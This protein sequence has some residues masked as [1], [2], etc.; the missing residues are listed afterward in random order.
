MIFLT[1]YLLASSH[2][3]PTLHHRAPRSAPRSAKAQ[4]APP[5]SQVIW[6]G[7]GGNAQHTA[8]SNYSPLGYGTVVW[9]APLDSDPPYT[10]GELFIHY[11]SVSLTAETLVMPFRDQNTWS[12][13]ARNISSGQVLW[14][15]LSSFKL[16]SSGFDWYPPVDGTLLPDASYAG[17][18]VAGGVFVRPH[19]DLQSQTVKTFYPFNIA[20]NLYY[21]IR[22]YGAVP[23]GLS[24]CFVKMSEAGVCTIY[25]C[26]ATH[27]P[28]FNAGPTLSNDGS[29][30]YVVEN[31]QNS[32][33]SHIIALST[34]TMQKT[35]DAIL[36]DPSGNELDALGEESSASPLV[37]PD[38]DVY[39]G[40][41]YGDYY[42]G[43]LTHFDKNLNPKGV[44]GAFGWDDTPSVVPASAV[45]AYTGTSSY[46]ICCKYNHYIEAGLPGNNMVAI[47]DPNASSID[48]YDNVP[49]MAP[50]VEVLGVTHDSRSSLT[51]AVREWCINSAAV[52]VKGKTIVLNSEDGS[53]YKWDLTQTS[54]T[55]NTPGCLTGTLTAHLQLTDGIGEAYTPT[56]IGKD[57]TVFAVDNARIYAVRGPAHSINSAAS[58]HRPKTTKSPVLTKR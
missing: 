41:M 11:G 9:S 47:L 54:M 26:A 50:V 53:V 28:T 42:R 58:L 25:N 7:Y 27:E 3:A 52:D 24:N 31:V 21:G 32:S 13:I 49:T 43:W 57:G 5:A 44:E 40:G 4:A 38:G 36:L 1:A 14:T 16:P 23:D 2:V 15:Y 33:E 17:P 18:S 45:P 6:T 34:A 10:S 48:P 29:T 20:G 56:V 30:I 35:A 22:S 51:T 12:F 37:G 39:F 19:T 46:L 55:A 8:I